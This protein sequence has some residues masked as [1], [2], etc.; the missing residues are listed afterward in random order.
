MSNGSS[1]SFA[2]LR[3]K[4]FIATADSQGFN[5]GYN[6]CVRLAPGSKQNNDPL[7]H[8]QAIRSWV[9]TFCS[10]GSLFERHP[11]KNDYQQKT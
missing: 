11:E 4:V 7:E 1:F 9:P 3:R 8:S 6:D 5:D 10:R 2:A